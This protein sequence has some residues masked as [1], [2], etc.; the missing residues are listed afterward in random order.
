MSETSRSKTDLLSFLFSFIFSAKFVNTESRQKSE[1][2]HNSKLFVWRFVEQ[3]LRIEQ[4]G[5]F[6]KTDWKPDLETLS[7]IFGSIRLS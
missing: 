3:T 4:K 1:H 2:T 7:H 6:G 5:L